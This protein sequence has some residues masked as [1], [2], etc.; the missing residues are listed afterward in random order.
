MLHICVRA[1]RGTTQNLCVRKLR[2]RVFIPYG[3]WI[4]VRAFLG[5]ALTLVYEVPSN[6]WKF[7]GSGIRNE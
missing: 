4:Y 1:Y 2:S 6:V 5:S 3:A 7:V